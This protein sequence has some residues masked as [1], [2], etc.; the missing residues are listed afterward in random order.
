MFYKYGQTALRIKTKTTIK[1]KKENKLTSRMKFAAELLDWKQEMLL[2]DEE[3]KVYA[4]FNIHENLKWVQ[5]LNIH[6]ILRWL[7]RGNGQK[8]TNILGLK[9]GNAEMLSESKCPQASWNQL[10]TNSCPDSQIQ[11]NYTQTSQKINK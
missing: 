10:L 7:Q 1:I 8:Y 3:L 5:T 6:G 4:I 11:S 9:A 2:L